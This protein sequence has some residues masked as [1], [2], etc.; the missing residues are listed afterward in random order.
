MALDATL[1]R[2][3]CCCLTTCPR[4]PSKSMRYPKTWS[5][6]KGHPISSPRTA[7]QNLSTKTWRAGV[8]GWQVPH[9]SRCLPK[10]GKSDHTKMHL[11][12]C[13]ISTDF[14][15]VFFLLEDSKY[16]I[17]M[18]VLEMISNNWMVP[19]N[20]KSFKL[21]QPLKLYSSSTLTALHPSWKRTAGWFRSMCEP[22]GFVHPHSWGKS[23][24]PS[25][26]SRLYYI[27]IS[28]EA[29]GHQWGDHV[30]HHQPSKL[31]EARIA[32][33]LTFHESSWL[34]N[35]DPYHGWT[36]GLLYSSPHT[37]GKFFH[38]PPPKK[39]TNNPPGGPLFIAHLPHQTDT[40]RS[41]NWCRAP[42]FA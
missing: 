9:E 15:H 26:F 11:I 7:F 28:F 8:S 1:L 30:D 27:Y 6:P 21:A 4:C 33:P 38:P 20:Y 37:T 29:V 23:P 25:Q 3:T 14:A 39:K 41:G 17:K 13:V 34:L 36:I 16:T 42:A 35:R 5:P 24:L 22:I 32:K 10:K 2:C 19:A 40:K 12:F 31:S 18:L